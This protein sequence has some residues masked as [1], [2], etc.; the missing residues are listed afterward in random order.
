MQYYNTIFPHAFSN[1]SL[2]LI[3]IFLANKL[4]FN[5]IDTLYYIIFKLHPN[6]RAFFNNQQAKNN[7]RPHSDSFPMLTERIFLLIGIIN[8]LTKLNPYYDN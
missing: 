7:L 5:L 3:S 6:Y 8:F 1:F 4:C 2:S